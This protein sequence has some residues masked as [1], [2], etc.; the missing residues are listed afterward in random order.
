MTG[1]FIMLNIMF[2]IHCL[3][4]IWY[5]HFGSWPYSYLQ[6]TACHY[7]DRFV[8]TLFYYD[9]SVDMWDKSC[10]GF[11]IRLVC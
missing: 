6:V 3:K 2:D 4:H 8:V 11:N 5:A 7:A 9:I 10:S 1:R